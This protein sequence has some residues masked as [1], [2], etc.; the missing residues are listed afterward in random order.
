M[1]R[2]VGMEVFAKVAA[3]GTLSAAARRQRGLAPPNS[4]GP[5]GNRFLCRSI[6]LKLQHRCAALG[7]LPSTGEQKRLGQR[8]SKAAFMRVAFSGGLR[9]V[10]E[11]R[12]ADLR[13]ARVAGVEDVA[14]EV[15][16]F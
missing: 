12:E 8:S 15:A 9:G 3:L 14:G 16:A 1:D 13:T 11:T 5:G 2:V 4:Q 7:V 6:T 10:N